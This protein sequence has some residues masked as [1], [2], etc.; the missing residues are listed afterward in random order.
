LAKADTALQ[1]HPLVNRLNLALESFGLRCVYA[2]DI[3]S[4]QHSL[5]LDHLQRGRCDHHE[6]RLYN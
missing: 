1:A 2:G 4:G 3:S 6:I 5:S